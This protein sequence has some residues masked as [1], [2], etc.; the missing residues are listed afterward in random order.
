[1]IFFKSSGLRPSMVPTGSFLN[2]L[3]FGAKMVAAAI[4]LSCSVNP[5][6]V[7]A[8]INSVKSP[9]VVSA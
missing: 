9:A 3:S 8:F 2:A 1:M 5:T 7:I 4:V 6:L